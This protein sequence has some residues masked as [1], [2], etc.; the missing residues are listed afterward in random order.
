MKLTIRNIATIKPAI[1]RD[2]Y[3]WDDEVAGFGLRVK[4]SGVYSFILQYR[5]AN[6][7]SRRI[8]LG[9]LGVLTPE[10]ARKRAQKKLAV[11][12]DGGDPAAERNAD[13][14]AI[15]VSELCDD[16]L[17]WAAT[18]P[19][20]VKAST[21]AEDRSRIERHVK[22]LLGNKPVASL[23]PDDIKK[24]QSDIAIGKTAKPKKDKG[25]GG[26]PRGGKGIAARTTG[27][28]A[29]ILEYAKNELKIIKDNPARGVERFK[30]NK[31]KR[32]LSLEEIKS[33]GEAM[34]NTE[35]ENRTGIAAI[36][37]LLLTGCRRNEILSLPWAW[38][39][40]KARCIRFED[41]KSGA[42]LRPIGAV[43]VTHLKA[44][45]KQET[46]KGK[47]ILWMFP[48]DKGEGHFIGLP[49]VLARL[50]KKA[51]IK[52][53]T[54]HTLRHTFAAIA[55]ELGYS[56]LTIAG[57]LGHTMP[58]VTAR[59]AHVPD[60]ALLTA[61]NAVSARI[62]AALSG[63]AKSAEVIPLVAVAGHS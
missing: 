48:A 26:Y 13:R 34:Q 43:A 6:G 20:P 21:L 38:F 31:K 27:M 45:P 49:K 54:L 9:K 29:T 17:K 36:R 18:R 60:R 25:K 42:Q 16:Y 37:T 24:F 5:N 51:K 40:E 35:K 57:L 33:L 56:E 58:D 47:E 44:Q 41:T 61:A 3:A 14:N 50:C 39:D 23:T 63:K 52:D 19:E 32:F 4:P 2:I 55:A 46:K 62:E 7:I 8:T 15:T 53:V 30:D 10:E 28:L 59:Y 12:A 1:G 11:V 22:E